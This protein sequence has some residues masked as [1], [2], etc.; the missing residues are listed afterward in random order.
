MMKNKK[1]KLCSSISDMVIR[2]LAAC[3]G[4]GGGPRY[5]NVSGRRLAQFVSLGQHGIV[6]V[7]PRELNDK[8]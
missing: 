4:A 6:L 7:K 5:R 8:V 1:R 3:D 2:V